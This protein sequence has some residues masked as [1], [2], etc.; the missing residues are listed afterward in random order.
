MKKSWILAIVALL[1]AIMLLL[2]GLVL[3][4]WSQEPRSAEDAGALQTVIGLREARLCR[5]DGTCAAVSLDRLGSTRE[6]AWIR[7]GSGAYA[8][9]WITAVLCLA[10]AGMAAAGKSSRLLRRTTL[11]AA[12]SAGV[13]GALFVGWA[14]PY[15][16]GS[17][18]PGLWL[19]AAGVLAALA[20]FFLDLRRS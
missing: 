9:A 19:Y 10:L 14:P 8:A 3:G 17:P 13:V 1:A 16:S 4:W 6:L 11:V 18:G 5:D 15:V 20:A 12:V 2:G 7:A